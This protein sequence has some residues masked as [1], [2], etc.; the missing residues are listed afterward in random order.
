M[1]WKNVLIVVVYIIVIVELYS[2][3]NYY[4]LFIRMLRAGQAGGIWS[5]RG[6][7]CV[8]WQMAV[9]RNWREKKKEQVL[10]T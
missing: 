5:D 3:S 2:P 8:W 9:K 10:N 6:A 4:L 1:I 7:G